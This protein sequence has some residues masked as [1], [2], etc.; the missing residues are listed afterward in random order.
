M[1][2]PEPALAVIA[3]AVPLTLL[4]G[5]AG[6]QREL[7]K[8]EGQIIAYRPA[9]RVSQVV[10]HVLNSESFLFKLRTARPKTQPVVTKVVYEHFGHSDLGDDVLRKTPML[11]ISARRDT[12]CD[13]TYHSFLQSSPTLKDAQT[14]AELGEKIIFISPFQTTKLS[15]GQLLKCY[16]LQNG[17]FRIERQGK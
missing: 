17:N 15:P 13:E 9:E 1:K 6:T 4:T 16:R 3:L 11:Q 5:P 12:T 10:S 14:G 8:I 7:T 2:R